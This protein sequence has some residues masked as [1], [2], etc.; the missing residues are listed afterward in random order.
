MGLPPAP[1]IA[2]AISGG[3]F[4]DHASPISDTT[5]IASMAS[6]TEHIDHVAT[7]LP[8]AMVAGVASV[9]AYAATGWWLMA[10]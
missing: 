9:I 1:F 7:Q 4:G 3:I 8:Y 10:V 2:A 6:G 5:I